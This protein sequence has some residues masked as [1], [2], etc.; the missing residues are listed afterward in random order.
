[1]EDKQTR[2]NNYRWYL[3]LTLSLIAATVA[4]GILVFSYYIKSFNLA[5]D[6]RQYNKYYVLITSDE[7]SS[8]WQ[9]VYESACEAGQ[10]ADS[11][12]DWLNRDF[13]DSYSREDLMRIAIA[14]DADGIIVTADET[15]AMTELIDRAEEAGIPVVTLYG[16]NTQSSRCS[17]VG[18][19]SYDMGMEYGRQ[20]LKLAEGQSCV[21]VMVLV[22][23]NAQ[24]FGQNILCSG[25][26]ETIEAEKE[27][28]M[29]VDLS[30]V[31]VDDANT[32]SAEESI[33][34]IFMEEELPDIIISLN[35][36]NTTCVYQAV[37]DHNKVGQVRILG[38]D[39]SETILNA[40][41]NNV[42]D[43]T[44]AIDT[45]QMGQYCVEA[46]VEYNDSGNTSQYFMADIA[47]IDL[48]NVSDYLGEEG[49]DE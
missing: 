43:A 22:N 41:E 27:A 3:I 34:D 5:Q 33:R 35:E 30:I 21:K 16:D 9:S 48:A 29:Q 45:D 8:L 4:V 37:V 17:Y 20:V 49:E 6:S 1:M 39:D 46:L 15:E 47:L 28:D 31:T 32:F 19:G 18:I 36:E 38:Y 10:E 40:I 2:K 24:D 12:V 42:I 14:S 25:L 26:Q 44:I 7:N 13:A 11:C 23:D